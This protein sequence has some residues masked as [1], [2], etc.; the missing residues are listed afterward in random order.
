MLPTCHPHFCSHPNG[1]CT[2]YVQ[3]IEPV[4]YDDWYCENYM[5]NQQKRRWKKKHKIYGGVFESSFILDISL[6][7]YVLHAG[8][9]YN[10]M[11]I[12]STQITI[13]YSLS[14]RAA[15]Q[16]QYH[17]FILLF[18]YNALFLIKINRIFKINNSTFF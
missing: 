4:Y 18:N 5:I 16:L 6:Y 15:I 17:F 14:I 13:V 3:Q 2:K 8:I 9:K 12:L 11:I 7:Y 1:I 10:M